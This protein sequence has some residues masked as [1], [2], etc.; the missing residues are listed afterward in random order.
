MTKQHIG[1]VIEVGTNLY[2]GCGNDPKDLEYSQRYE[3]SPHG[4]KAA[5]RRAVDFV[6]VT[7]PRVLRLLSRI[8][9]ALVRDDNAPTAYVLE[10][11]GSGYVECTAGYTEKVI[12]VNTTTTTEID[13]ALRF[14]SEQ[15]AYHTIEKA[16]LDR[17]YSTGGSLR[18]RGVKSTQKTVYSVEP[19]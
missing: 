18:V 13:C 8:E 17:G 11:V 12:T 15:K 5:Y 7:V 6:D 1:Y 9:Y 4:L 2:V 3:L 14:A 16:A 10:V 19:L